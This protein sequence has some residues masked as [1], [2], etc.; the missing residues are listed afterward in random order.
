MDFRHLEYIVTIAEEQKISFACERLFDSQPALS[1]HL[2][3]L[4]KELGVA[5]F[6]RKNNTMLLTKAGSCTSMRQ[7]RFL[8]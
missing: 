4:E 2:I 8:T 3:K 7:G 5:L 1:Q 6:E